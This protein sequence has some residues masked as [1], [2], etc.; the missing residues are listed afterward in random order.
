MAKSVAPFLIGAVALLVLG[1]KKSGGGGASKSDEDGDDTD[2][3]QPRQ[4][5]K[6]VA[7]RSVNIDYGPDPDPKTATM[8]PATQ[9]SPSSPGVPSTAH[10]ADASNWDPQWIAMEEAILAKV[11]EVRAAGYT[12]A[13]GYWPPVPPLRMNEELRCSARL[14]SKDMADRNYFSHTNPEGL[15]SWDRMRDAGYDY[16]HATENIAAGFD[17]LDQT[18]QQWLTSQMGHCKGIMDPESTEI[19]IGYY[20]KSSSQYRHYWTQNFGAPA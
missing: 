10:C 18:M 4:V 3:G 12:C 20:P 5:V 2:E 14:H 6:E 17:D 13:S 8:A 9:S 11:N 7:M 1:G 16:S 19:G 15:N